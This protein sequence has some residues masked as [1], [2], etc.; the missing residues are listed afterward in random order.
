MMPV[1]ESFGELIADYD[2][3]SFTAEQFYDYLALLNDDYYSI[4]ATSDNDAPHI[5]Q[6]ISFSTEVTT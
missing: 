2:S 4:P 1:E 5:E 6:N 3:R